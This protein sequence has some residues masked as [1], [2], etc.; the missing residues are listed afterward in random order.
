VDALLRELTKRYGGRG[1]G[2]ADLAQGGGLTGSPL[3]VAATA[4]A[5]I[6]AGLEQ[7]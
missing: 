4:R 7:D 3:E 2:K 6:V 5:A 1:G